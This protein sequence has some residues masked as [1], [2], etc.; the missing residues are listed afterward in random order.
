MKS[1]C[2]KGNSLREKRPDL[3]LQWD[4]SLNGSLT[5]DN[6]SYGSHARV[7]WT[8][9]DCGRSYQ[10]SVGSRTLKG[11]GC[12][13]CSGLKAVPG[14]N[15]LAAMF[16]DTAVQWHPERNGTLDADHVLPQSSLY[17]W[18]CCEEGHEWPASPQS[19][20]NGNRCPW[21]AHRPPV[22]TRLV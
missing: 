16:P 22:I 20:V 21:C 9:P 14:V 13:Y 2:M 7:Y 11:S 19:R 12:P 10:A 15:S 3:A 4:S 8:C 17:V 5:P 1:N 18:W 6:T